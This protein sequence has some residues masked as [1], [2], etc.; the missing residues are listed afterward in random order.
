MTELEPLFDPGIPRYRRW[1]VGAFAGVLVLGHLADV[2]TGSEHWP[3]SCYPMYAR[4]QRSTSYET[5]RLV[6]VTVGAPPREVPMDTPFLR[7][8]FARLGRLPDREVRLQEAVE[9]YA[10]AVGWDRPNDF[11]PF[12]AY[13]VYEQRWTLRADVDP[14]RPPDRATLL[15]ELRRPGGTTVAGEVPRDVSP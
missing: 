6:G 4:L 13:R 8:N 14:V 11:G 12:N 7:S 2:V 10:N 9:V 3:F 1:L 5:I 15:A